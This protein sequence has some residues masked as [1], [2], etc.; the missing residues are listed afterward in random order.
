MGISVSHCSNG[1][2]QVPNVGM[3]LL[4]AFVGLVY[5]PVAFPKHF[6]RRQIQVPAG[7]IKF[8]VRAGMGVHVLARTLGPAGTPKYAIYATDFYLS[9][10]YGKASNVHAGIEINHYNSYYNYIVKYDFFADHQ[11]LRASV[12]TAYLAHELMIGHF[13]LLTQGG[14]NVYN[15]FYNNYIKMYLSERG[16]KTELKKYISARLGV[17][18]YL[19]DPKYCSRSNIYLGAY[20]KANFGQAD[21]TCVQLGY[22]F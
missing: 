21:F 16:M 22:V 17:Q 2:Y 9:R 1:H 15:Q 5:H 6:E 11:K 20:I 14:I 12:V 19:F 7:K 10:L 4:S 18:Y 8:N 3:N 13:S